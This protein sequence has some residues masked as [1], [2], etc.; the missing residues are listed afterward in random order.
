MDEFCGNALDRACPGCTT[1]GDSTRSTRP[2]YNDVQVAW[3]KAF[4]MDGLK[5]ALGVNNI[6]GE[7]PPIC[8]LL[9][10]RL[11]RGH[12]RPAGYVLGGDGQVRLLVS[13]DGERGDR[14]VPKGGAV[15]NPDGASCPRYRVTSPG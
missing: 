15:R 5:L 12:L 9:A 13:D 8:Y 10:Q 1:G 14:R 3:N 11:R 2:V 6:F 7:D 4:T